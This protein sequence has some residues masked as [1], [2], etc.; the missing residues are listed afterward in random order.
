MKIGILALQGAVR[1]HR[2][3]LLQ[4]GVETVDVLY[5]RDLEGIDGLILPGGESTTVG[6]LLIRYELLDPITE[7]GRKGLPIFG[8]C[9]GMILLAKEIIG[10]TQPRFGLMDIAVERNAF[11][12]QLASFEADL[13]IPALGSVPFHT[14]FIRAPYIEKTGERVKA[15]LTYERKVIFAEE[16]NLLAAAFHPELTDDTRV[17]EYFLRKIKKR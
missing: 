7:S 6:K 15:L 3:A 17:H 1:E 9:T 4:L 13:E 2:N 5:P 16:D 12:R 10:S 8:T 11:G 14:V